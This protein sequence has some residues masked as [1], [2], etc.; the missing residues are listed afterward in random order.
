MIKILIISALIF[1]VPVKAASFETLHFEEIKGNMDF[2]TSLQFKEYCA[3]IK[4][5]QI[6]WQGYV[7]DVKKDY[8]GNYKVKIDMDAPSWFSIYDVTL[9]VSKYDA[10]KLKKG[11]RISFSGTIKS[12]QNIFGNCLVILGD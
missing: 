1:L 8:S 7:D 4:G 11:S 10:L 5:R 3:G 2:M 6:D 9:P 12:V